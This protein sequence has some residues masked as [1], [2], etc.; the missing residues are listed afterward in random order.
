MKIRYLIPLTLWTLGLVNLFQ[1]F[2]GFL[3][4]FSTFIFWL[5]LISHLIECVILRKRILS[6]ADAPT[7]AFAMTFLFGVIYL[8]SIEAKTQE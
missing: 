3:F 1:P 5:L 7:K 4:Y 6:S 8:V 2:N